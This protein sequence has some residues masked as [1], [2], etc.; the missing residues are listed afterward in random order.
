M[1]RKN[2]KQQEQSVSKKL[3]LFGC[4]YV[5]S[6]KKLDNTPLNNFIFGNGTPYRQR[7]CSFF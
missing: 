5:T 4:S 2:K 1:G 3:K 6:G 7:Q